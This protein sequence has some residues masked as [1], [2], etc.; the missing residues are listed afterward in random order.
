MTANDKHKVLPLVLQNTLVH[1]FSL[2]SMDALPCYHLANIWNKTVVWEHHLAFSSHK[3]DAGRSVETTFSDLYQLFTNP[4]LLPPLNDNP[5][6]INCCSVNCV[7]VNKTSHWNRL[8]E[9]A[10]SSFFALIYLFATGFIFLVTFSDS[11]NKVRLF[12]F[13]A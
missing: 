7:L 12:F 8:F 5:V 4:A 9:L 3:C 2:L 1:I 13:L 11:R 10:A 6:I